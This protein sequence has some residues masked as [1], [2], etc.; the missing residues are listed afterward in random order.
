V[1]TSIQPYDPM[2]RTI[3]GTAGG[4]GITYTWSFMKM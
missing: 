1:A 3:S 4:D 2:V